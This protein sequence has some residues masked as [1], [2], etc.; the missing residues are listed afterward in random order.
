MKNLFSKLLCLAVLA[1]AFAFPSRAQFVNH[2]E[3]STLPV[4]EF[5]MVSANGDFEVTLS[6]GSYG[7]RLTTDK[8]LTPYVQV[9]VRSNTLYLTYDE[10]SVP[11][12]IKKLYKGK[13]ASQPVFRAVVS[14]PQLNGIEL[15]DNVIL[16]SAEAFYGSDIVISLTDK[17]QVRNLTVQG[18]SI[19]VNMKKNAQAALTLTADKKM[20]VTTDDKAILK[21]AEK[22]REITLNA[23]GNSDN[24]LSGEGEILNLNLSEKTTSN[25][26]HRTKNAVL[27]VGG[28]SKLILTGTGEYL[29]VKGGKNAEVEAVAFPVKTM[30]AELDGGKVNVAVEKEMNVTLLGGSSLFFTGSP[31]LIVNKIVKST[32]APAGTV[33]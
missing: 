10:K 4:G 30:K 27:N 15:D 5:T 31:T 14:M 28:S 11:K 3:E 2:L 32:L 16:S 25:V 21:L 20:E 23:K 17:A 7:V 26:S 19:T 33:K 12:D 22:A 24:A 1:S 13:N 8:N 6:K 29:E 9:Y 18:N